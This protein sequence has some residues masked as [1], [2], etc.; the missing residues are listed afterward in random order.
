MNFFSG[1]VFW[2]SGWVPGKIHDITLVRAFGL[3]EKIG[4]NERLIAD[5]GYVGEP[6]KII[7]P[8]KGELTD[9]QAEF[10]D[11]LNHIRVI[12]ENVYAQV[13]SF[14]CMSVPW[15]HHLSH[16]K[17]AWTVILNLVNA[18]LTE[19]PLREIKV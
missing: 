9:T 2:H 8:F 15:R 7:T 3:L 1:K 16:H 19:F 12:V 18:N 4:P 17:L 13:K 5:K 6:N 11:T 14:K 10:N